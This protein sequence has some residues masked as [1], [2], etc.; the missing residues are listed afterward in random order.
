[1]INILNG[2]T[3]VSKN[4]LLLSRNS[5]AIDCDRFLS[6]YSIIDGNM[7]PII[8]QNHSKQDGSAVFM[9]TD[10][11]GSTEVFDETDGGSW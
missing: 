8:I 3:R 7:F 9:S 6:Y 10:I 2:T 11:Y 5:L 1:M 4:K